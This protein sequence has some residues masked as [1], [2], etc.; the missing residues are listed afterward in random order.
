MTN[1]RA[2]RHLDI[3]PASPLVGLPR[4]TLLAAL[5]VS[6]TLGL[7]ACVGGKRGGND[8]GTPPWVMNPPADTAEVMHGVGEGADLGAARR[9]A[10]RDIAGK[11]KVT[12]S[13]ASRSQTTVANG[14]V[15]RSASESVLA[16]VQKTEFKS[17]TLLKSAATPGGVYALVAVNRGEWLGETRERIAALHR[18]ALAVIGSDASR[19]PVEQYVALRRA[20]ALLEAEKS[21]YGVFGARDLNAADRERQAEI[22]RLQTRSTELAGI[23]VLGVRARND[24]DAGSAVSGFLTDA[25]LRTAGAGVAANGFVDVTV[26]ERAETVRNDRL[27]RLSINL[28][29]RDTAQR[30]LA[31]R[32]Y[33]ATGASLIDLA[34]ARQQAIRKFQTDLK[35]AGL[36]G[37]L[38]IQPAPLPGTDAR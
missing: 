17:H 4:R 25:G 31:S 3:D 2:R 32:D 8:G 18:Q 38:G 9:A 23:V 11:L 6:A 14:M 30:A 37:G 19:G 34:G 13:G 20:G 16:E 1:A 24:A 12:I 15:D 28:T 22:D 36:L 29:L 10:L 35:N 21:L 27:V 26:N 5:T 33:V 7:G